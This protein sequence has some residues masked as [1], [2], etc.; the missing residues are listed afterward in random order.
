MTEGQDALDSDL[1]SGATV[2]EA[3]LRRSI[4]DLG[5]YVFYASGAV[6]DRRTGEIVWSPGDPPGN[7]PRPP[8]R[9]YSDKRHNSGYFGGRV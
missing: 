6:G 4:A 9:G 5:P 1:R 2:K 3:L 8:E 7:R